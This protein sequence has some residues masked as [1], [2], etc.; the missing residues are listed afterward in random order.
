MNMIWVLTSL[1]K[2]NIP[3]A[4]HMLYERDS[5]KCDDLMSAGTME[6]YYTRDH[7][8]DRFDGDNGANDLTK[9]TDDNK[10]KLLKSFPEH[11]IPPVLK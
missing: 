5:L 8:A 3:D 1:Y 6:D 2:I 9:Y 4:A 11:S 7:W 10:A